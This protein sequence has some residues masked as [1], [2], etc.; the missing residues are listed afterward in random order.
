MGRPAAVKK[1]KKSGLL[2]RVAVVLLL[3]AIGIVL[4]D[5][6]LRPELRMIAQSR[7]QQ[8]ADQLTAQAVAQVLGDQGEISLVQVQRQEGGAI[9]SIETDVSAANRLKSSVELAL[10]QAFSAEQLP[11]FSIPLGNLSGLSFLSGGGP[12]IPF[13]LV[14]AGSPQVNWESELKGEGINQTVHRVRLTVGV[15]VAALL[16]GIAV[17]TE[18]H[19]TYLAAETVIVGQVPQF[20]AGMQNGE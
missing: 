5:M 6:R 14:L 7:A 19:T 13:T 1:R 12:Q 4:L 17:E 2:F 9:A 20:F 18:S 10:A 3:A 8:L 15:R 16:P 11:Q